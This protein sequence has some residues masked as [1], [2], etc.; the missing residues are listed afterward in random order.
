MS[1]LSAVPGDLTS[2]V[3]EQARRTLNSLAGSLPGR[4]RAV[5]E[6]LLSAGAIW[7][8]F[9]SETDRITVKRLQSKGLA[10]LVP[11]RP[12]NWVAELPDGFG[13]PAVTVAL[14]QVAVPP[15]M[16]PQDIEDLERAVH[17]RAMR[18]AGRHNRERGY[19][20]TPIP[21]PEGNTIGWRYRMGLREYGW[22]TVSGQL[23][24]ANTESLEEAEA[25]A[26]AAYAAT[27]VPADMV[28][29]AQQVH[30]TAHSFR[31]VPPLAPAD[32]DSGQ[33]LGWTFQCLAPSSH[34]VGWIAA[35]RSVRRG[36]LADE[37]PARVSLR[38]VHDLGLRAEAA[39]RIVREP[40]Q[41]PGLPA[42]Q[43]R[44]LAIAAH[45]DARELLAFTAI[46]G[47]VLGYTYRTNAGYGWI[48]A[49]LSHARHAQASR[50]KADQVLALALV[51]DRKDGRT[52][53]EEAR[54]L[55]VDCGDLTIG[56]AREA[57][58]KRHKAC[59]FE[60]ACGEDGD[61]LGWTYAV[62]DPPQYGHRTIRYG[63][64]T[65]TGQLGPLATGRDDARHELA[66]DWV[67]DQIV[68]A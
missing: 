52:G 40:S 38:R 45:P 66:R 57:V 7:S 50:T 5:F 46:D 24:P 19:D 26:L 39:Q 48:T 53:A 11:L 12:D 27:A 54:V 22:V 62:P 23:P 61:L 10:R 1:P 2:P 29:A 42:D 36:L 4:E 55:L 18:E 9:A 34:R 41:L 20:Y 43:A 28:R 33:V 51:Q 47:S 68:T 3:S 25:Q 63:R 59:L 6:K 37:G 56:A 21:G 35:D 31:P 58:G 8:A 13:P 44:V 49:Y 16:T 65:V 32:E 60:A 64:I 15:P 30:P 14:P 17:G 67:T